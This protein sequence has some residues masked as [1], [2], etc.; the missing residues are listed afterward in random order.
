MLL[1]QQADIQKL[2]DTAE[3]EERKEFYKRELEAVSAMVDE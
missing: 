3:T 2:V 1:Q